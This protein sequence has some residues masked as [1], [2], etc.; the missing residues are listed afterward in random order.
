MKWALCFICTQECIPTRE[1]L[2]EEMTLAKWEC[3]GVCVPRSL[4]VATLILLG[5]T[6]AI[7]WQA[8]LNCRGGIQINAH[9]H[10]QP[11]EPHKRPGLLTGI[12]GEVRRRGRKRERWRRRRERKRG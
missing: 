7:Y 5:Y 10:T 2:G 11:P 12:Q 6:F 1:T 8:H 3:Q 4:L 9:S